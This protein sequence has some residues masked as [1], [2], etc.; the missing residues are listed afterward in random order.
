[1]G[2]WNV[3][4]LAGDIPNNK[5]LEIDVLLF[6]QKELVKCF[7]ID[8]ELYRNRLIQHLEQVSNINLNTFSF[9]LPFLV[10]QYHIKVSNN[11]LSQKLKRMIGD[12]G[13]VERGF[14]IP[15]KKSSAYP[16]KENN[17]NNFLSPFDYAVQLRDYWNDIM[18]EKKGFNDLWK[19]EDAFSLPVTELAR[20]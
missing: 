4:P 6:S 7:D 19:K 9:I 5:K 10:A 20:N 1:M 18:I 14:V 2:Y 12:G 3:H 8:D 15:S 17:W 13:A 16:R 11:I